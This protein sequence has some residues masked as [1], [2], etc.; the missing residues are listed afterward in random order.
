MNFILTMQN[1]DDGVSDLFDCNKKKE[2]KFLFNGFFPFEENVIKFNPFSH[3]ES[4]ISEIH[5]DRVN[6]PLSTNN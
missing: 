5:N 6:M 2:K 3:R 1:T 4:T